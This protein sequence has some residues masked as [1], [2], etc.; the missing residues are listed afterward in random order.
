MFSDYAYCVQIKIFYSYCCYDKK[1]Q[2]LERGEKTGK[3]GVFLQLFQ[4]A[5][6]PWI[7]ELQAQYLFQNV[8]N[9]LGYHICKNIVIIQICNVSKHK[10][11]SV[12]IDFL[13]SRLLGFS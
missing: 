10:K 3:K 11:S 8:A 4:I 2:K 7:I 5:V 1:N 13:F 9:D 12:Y 6:S